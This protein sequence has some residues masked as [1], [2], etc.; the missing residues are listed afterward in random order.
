M[1]KNSFGPKKM[2]E[3]E[4]HFLIFVSKMDHQFDFGLKLG[5]KQIIKMFFNLVYV[6]FGRH[7]LKSFFKAVVNKREASKCYHGDDGD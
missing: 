6:D 5:M 4:F 3:K 1:T 7:L 2:V